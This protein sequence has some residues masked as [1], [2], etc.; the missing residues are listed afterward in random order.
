MGPSPHMPLLEGSLG[1]FRPSP[2]LYP[3][4]PSI[5]KALLN[6]GLLMLSDMLANDPR[7]TDRVITPSL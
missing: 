1:F 5:Y 3:N 4:P 2:P 6:H 7:D